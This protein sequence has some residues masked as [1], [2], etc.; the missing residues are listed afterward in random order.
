LL[1]FD[2]V[3]LRDRKGPPLLNPQSPLAD[4]LRGPIRPGVVA[5]IGIRPERRQAVVP[6]TTAVL[7][8]GCGVAGD[9]ARGLT[10]Q[11]TLMQVEHL[12]AIAAYLGR[13]SVD[14]ALLRRNVVV[15]G[16]NLFA[17]KGRTFRMGGAILQATGEC[18]P[19]SRME[20]ILGPGG[21]NAV[22]G[23]G[24]ITARVL[25]GGRIG[26]GDTLDAVMEPAVS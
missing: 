15:R 10:R 7:D 13:E 8:P 25:E 9:H 2:K 20:D 21:Y 11:V 1:A 26:L 4:L 17:L 24:G 14:P 3:N 6:V 18:H 22:R 12:T 19:C 23:H 16:I 5:W